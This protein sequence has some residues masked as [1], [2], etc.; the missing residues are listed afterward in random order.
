[1]FLEHSRR[2]LLVDTISD[3]PST[4]SLGNPTWLA[5]VT[6]SS[7]TDKLSSAFYTKGWLYQRLF[8]FP[9]KFFS[10]IALTQSIISFLAFI[11][12]IVIIIIIIIIIIIRELTSDEDGSWSVQVLCEIGLPE[13]ES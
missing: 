4:I 11:T 1:M 7:T 5:A 12:F 10:P 3:I 2:I 9:T 13:N 6:N 8:S